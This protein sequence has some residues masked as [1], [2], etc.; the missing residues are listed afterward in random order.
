MVG[1]VLGLVGDCRSRLIKRNTGQGSLGQVSLDQTASSQV[2]ILGRA[3]V[4]VLDQARVGL[5]LVSPRHRT[6][7]G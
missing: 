3:Q 6:G 7:V 2:Q 1:L 4:Q 5:D